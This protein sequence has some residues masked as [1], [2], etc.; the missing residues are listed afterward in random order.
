MYTV[1]GEVIAVLHPADKKM[2]TLPDFEYDKKV[3][4]TD[5]EFENLIK[6][7]KK[8]KMLTDGFDDP[9]TTMPDANVYMIPD[10][11]IADI[12]VVKSVKWS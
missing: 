7:T 4:I 5:A 3:I 6:E 9:T 11:K 8:K 12:E 2:A 1:D 10:Q